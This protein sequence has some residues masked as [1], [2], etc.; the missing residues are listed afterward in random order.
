MKN[1]QKLKIVFI[2]DQVQRELPSLL[3]LKKNI[4]KYMNADAYIIGS[5]AEEQRIYYLLYKI[6]PDIVFISQIQEE[7]TRRIAKYVRESGGILCLLPAEVTYSR[8]NLFWLFN[9]NLSYKDYVDYCFLPGEQYRNDLNELTDIDKRK[10]FV[11][12]APKMDL[13]AT[14]YKNKF[15]TRKGFCQKHKIPLNKKNLFIYTTFL[16]ISSTNYLEKEN[17]FKGNVNA[18][19][20]IYNCCDETKRIFIRDIKKICLD[21][22]EYNIIL[23]PHP[24]EEAKDY[25]NINYNNFFLIQNEVFNNTISSID[26]TIHWNSTVAT[27]CWVKN[28]KTL[29]YSPILKYQDLLSD[30]KGGNPIYNNYEE[31]KEG[32]IKHMN[33]SMEQRY[34][35]FQERYLTTWF[36]KIDG[37]SSKRIAIKLNQLLKEKNIKFFSVKYKCNCHKFYNIL[38]FFE[39]FLGVKLTRILLLVLRPDYKWRYAIDNYINI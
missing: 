7:V 32:I 4:E 36:Y 39:F 13:L 22:P 24:L 8:L 34:L 9:K 35:R 29:Q 18:I 20:R 30:F 10:I 25:L 21:F 11:V 37:L 38:I 33:N 14:V 15:L 5:L 6:K 17:S 3:H 12:G 26:L 1:R 27:E 16:S 28:I 31:L 2:C 23:K 19:R